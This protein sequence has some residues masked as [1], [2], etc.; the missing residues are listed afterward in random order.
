MFCR[1]CVRSFNS[2]RLYSTAAILLTF[3]VGAVTCESDDPNVG[4]DVVPCVDDR[5]LVEDTFLVV[6]P[7][8]EVDFAQFGARHGNA[9]QAGVPDASN[10]HVQVLRVLRVVVGE[11]RRGAGTSI[12][13]YLV[14]V[15]RVCI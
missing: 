2:F 1:S 5:T 12:G 14:L 10:V 13:R 6:F 9:A 4:E 15:V 8:A 7:M 11:R 3:Q